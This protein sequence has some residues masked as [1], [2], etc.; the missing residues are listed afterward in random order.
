MTI[1]Q[2]HRIA[3]R[4]SRSDRR[5]RELRLIEDLELESERIYIFTRLLIDKGFT[6]AFKRN[7]GIR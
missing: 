4:D 5:R 6:L 3:V 2:P 7:R 1:I